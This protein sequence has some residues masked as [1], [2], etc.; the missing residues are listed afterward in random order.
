MAITNNYIGFAI[1]NPAELAKAD[2]DSDFSV[3]LNRSLNSINTGYAYSS[4]I[5]NTYQNGF[6]NKFGSSANFSTNEQ[7]MVQNMIRESIN[8]NGITIRYMP[9]WSP[10]TDGVWN[11]RPESKFHKGTEMD[12]ILVATSGFEGEGDV[13]T[14]YGIEFREEIIMSVA[15]NRFND[16]YG[17]FQGKLDSETVDMF[18]RTR[19][20][21]GDL[22]VIPFGRSA[23]NKNQY[24]PKAFEILRVTTFND[25]AFFQ[26]GDN[27]QYKI[28]AR[29]FELSGE[30]M[31]FNPSVVKYDPV[32][33]KALTDSDTDTITK[34][35]DGLSIID[36]ETRSI[37]ITKDSELNW[38]SWADNQDIEEEAQHREVYDNKGKFV[39]K[40]PVL[41]D[42]Y[43]AKAH[44][45]PGVINDL[46]NI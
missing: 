8:I 29:L 7:R 34:A 14:Q 12:M 31:L 19:P 45:M 13:M 43:T 37:N 44:G 25:G 39:E 21:E 28:K 10:Y 16:L 17:Q 9:R 35:L 40:A 41:V 24:F 27:Y 2:L 38:D 23:N 20:M 6:I 30:D 1:A 33:G 46:D 42:D 15:I 5:S 18:R 26:L 36:S 22:I 3:N 11:E 4:G 32:S